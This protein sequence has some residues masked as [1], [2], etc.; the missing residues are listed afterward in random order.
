MQESI[1]NVQADVFHVHDPENQ[2]KKTLLASDVDEALLFLKHEPATAGEVATINDKKL[3]RKIDW[4]LMPLMFSV[5]YLQYTDKTLR[6]HSCE[7]RDAV[8]LTNHSFHCFCHGCYRRHA[9][10]CQWFLAPSNGFLCLIS[11]LRTSPVHAHSEIS[12][13]QIP[14]NQWYVLTP[15][16]STRKITA[17]VTIWGIVVTMNCVCKSFAPLVVLRVLL[18]VFES[19]VAPR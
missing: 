9:Y 2:E 3:L 14:R 4:L 10:A 8:G 15:L 17:L 18:G 13:C 11:R 7:R 6:E 1:E 5:Y 16:F 12:N 19:C